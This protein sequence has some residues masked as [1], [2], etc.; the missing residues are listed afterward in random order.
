LQI[1]PTSPRWG[2]FSEAWRAQPFAVF[3]FNSVVVALESRSRSS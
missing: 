2:N 1:I 3:Y